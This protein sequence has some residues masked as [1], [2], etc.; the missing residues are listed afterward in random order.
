MRRNVLVLPILLF[1]CSCNGIS[2]QKAKA[3]TRVET[4]IA[5]VVTGQN[6]HSSTIPT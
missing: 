1:F 2:E 6:S 4:E 5:S 3:P